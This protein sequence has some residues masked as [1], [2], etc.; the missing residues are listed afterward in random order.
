WLNLWWFPR[1]T[2]ALHYHMLPD[3][4]VVFRVARAHIDVSI[5]PIGRI[6]L[7]RDMQA[8]V[9]SASDLS[10]LAVDLGITDTVRRFPGIKRLVVVPHEVIA[11]VPFAA[12][13]VD[14]AAL[15]ERVALSQIDRLGQLRRGRRAIDGHRVLG[16]AV[17]D[18]TGSGLPDLRSTE[19]E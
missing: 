15:C 1:R 16:V 8:L 5:L 4:T 3:R 10:A 6:H 9:D 7:Q 14:G 11:E 12:L 19:P 18:Y 17:S 13:R 2:V